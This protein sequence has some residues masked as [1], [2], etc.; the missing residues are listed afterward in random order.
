MMSPVL[1]NGIHRCM[2]LVRNLLL[3]LYCGCCSRVPFINVHLTSL[4]YTSGSTRARWFCADIAATTDP[5]PKIYPGLRL[6]ETRIM[7]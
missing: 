7:V 6:M 1:G 3:L 4:L 5:F 2:D